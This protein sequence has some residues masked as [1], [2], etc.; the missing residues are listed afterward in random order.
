MHRVVTGIAVFLLGALLLP[1]QTVL[2][3]QNRELLV[4]SGNLTGMQDKTGQQFL[5]LQPQADY[6]A[7]RQSPIDASDSPL[8]TKIQGWFEAGTAAGNMGDFY[9]NRDGGHS[10][11]DTKRFGQM[12]VLK[13]GDR[14]KADKL[15]FGLKTHVF[16]SRPTIANASLAMTGTTF[17]RSMA[18]LILHNPEMSP[19]LYAM[20]RMGNFTFYPEHHDHDGVD[21]FAVNTPYLVISQGSS[22]SDQPFMQAFA[23]TLASFQPAVKERLQQQGMLGPTVQMIFRWSNEGVGNAENYLTGR[24]HP[25][26][27]DASHLRPDAM[28]E[29]AHAIK[30]DCLPPIAL[31]RLT[32]ETPPRQGVDYF[33]DG[34]GELL[35]ETPCAIGRIA[36]SVQRH[37][38]L[39]VSATDSVDLHQRPL[40]YHWVVLRGDPAKVKIEPLNASKTEVEITL[41]Y[42]PQ[43]NG[44]GS[45]KSS[46]VDIGVFVDN[47]VYYSPPAFISVWYP[48]NEERV[49]A[50]NGPREIRYLPVSENKAADP[51]L[52]FEKDWTDRYE[53]HDSQISGWVREH[54]N[55]DE[56]T[57]NAEGQ[58][59]AKGQPADVTYTIETLEGGLRKIAY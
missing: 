59:V 13:F 7:L 8:A 5:L 47:G 35:M 42:Q 52:V 11:L 55:G 45:I 49:Y 41:D 44:P 23:Q 56:E 39:R 26:V 33:D 57:F 9:E 18:R 32:R 27:F 36:R 28:A 51:L 20:Y 38:T 58:R 12:T 14:L 25:T 48:P 19:R 4:T 29:M 30:P 43:T 21:L 22:A 50:K 53:Y 54:A 31:I 3:P 6:S 34:V 2:S 17:A 10:R 15:D 16:N 46:R 37:R 24:A 1:A 40:N